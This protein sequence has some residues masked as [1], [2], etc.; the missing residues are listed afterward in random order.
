MGWHLHTPTTSSG[1]RVT[2]TYPP[3]CVQYASSRY[4]LK[5]SEADAIIMFCLEVWECNWLWK[6]VMSDGMESPSRRL[7]WWEGD[8][9]KVTVHLPPTATCPLC[10]ALCHLMRYFWKMKCTK[11][12]GWRWRW[13]VPRDE[14]EKEDVNCSVHS[15]DFH[16]TV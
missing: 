16:R 15:M 13:S 2:L 4:L 7:E 9:M 8:V 11:R 5:N 1:S 14:D 12:W 6:E 3:L 10:K